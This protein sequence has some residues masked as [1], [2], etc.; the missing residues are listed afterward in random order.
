MSEDPTLK[1]IAAR[2]AVA[3]SLIETGRTAKALAYL[4][5]LMEILP[6]PTDH[7]LDC[8][9]REI[10]GK[11]RNENDIGGITRSVTICK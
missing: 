11:D 7:N 6:S 1:A 4:R 5:D 2:V 8:A 9:M 10:S 3:T